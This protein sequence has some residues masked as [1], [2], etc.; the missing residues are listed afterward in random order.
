[1]YA[2]LW[3]IHVAVWQKTTTFCKAIILQ[4]KK[5]KRC[6]TWELRVKLYLGQNEVYSPGGSTAD[7]SER[8]LQRGSGGSLINKILGK[9]E[10]NATKHS[11]YK[12]FSASREELTSP[13]RDLVFFLDMSWCTDWDHE[14]GSWRYLTKDLS[15]QI[16]WSTECLTP[17][18]IPFGECWRSSV[19]AA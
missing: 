9:G 16:T 5:K 4:L 8:L 12:R 2:Y 1:M 19:A 3:R 11:F 10:F 6:S 7:S 14:I 15:H 13:W 17:L 18:W